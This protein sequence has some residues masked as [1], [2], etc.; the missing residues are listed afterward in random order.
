MKLNKIKTID[1]N[2]L[3]SDLNLK[4]KIF[5]DLKKK[6]KKIANPDFKVI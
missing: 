3:K 6:I 4:K 5:V 2:F 1:L